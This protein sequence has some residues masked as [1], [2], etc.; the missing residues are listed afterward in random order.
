MADTGGVWAPSRRALTAGI[1]ASITLSATELL[2][3]ATALPAVADELGR[4][5]YGVAISSF[6]VASVLGVL[7]GGPAADRLGPSRPY[8]TAVAAFAAGL[9]IA[10]SAQSMAQFIAGRAVQGLGAGAMTPVLYAAIGRG[11]RDEDSQLRMFSLTSTAWVLPGVAGP[12]LAGLVTEH[13]GWR[14]V[15]A[16]MAPFVVLAA[17]VTGAGLRT[18]SGSPEGD[19]GAAGERR[20]PVPAGPGDGRDGG[21][22]G[23][24]RAPVVPAVAFT[25]AAALV[26]AGSGVSA[27]PVAVALAAAGLG[28]GAAAARAGRFLPAGTLRL[29][30]GSP[31]AVGSRFLLLYGFVAVDAFVPLAVTDV[32][33]RSVLVGSLAVTAGTLTWTGGTWT[34]E[35]L[36]KRLGP[37]PILRLGFAVLGAGVAIQMGYVVAAVPLAVALVGTA[38]A[39]YG[40]GM[41]YGLQSALVLGAAPEGEEGKAS[42]WVALADTLAFAAGPAVTGALVAVADRGTGSLSGMLAAGWAVSLAACLAGVV[43]S[44]RAAPDGRLPQ[45]DGAEVGSA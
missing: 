28:L 14:W 7:L 11:Y 43:V 39:G 44:S 32:R 37:G 30:P 6:A 5:G 12:G 16:G 8:L 40:T 4:T 24:T 9:V 42:S 3:V 41:A 38:L 35:R 2:A 22:G 45:H 13:L 10:G 1:V 23:P 21:R 31:A 15:F 33:G 17:V 18:V 36:V 29:V 34:A 25:V 19:A 26:L 20:P 27:W